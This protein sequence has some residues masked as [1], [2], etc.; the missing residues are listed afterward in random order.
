MSV[1]AWRRDSVSP[2]QRQELR[3]LGVD[4][5]VLSM[6]ETAGQAWT[7]LELARKSRAEGKSLTSLAG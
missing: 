7:L 2:E 5:T 1:A 6:I 4:E 3:E